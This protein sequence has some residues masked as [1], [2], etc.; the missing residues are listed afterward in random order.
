VSAHSLQMGACVIVYCVD[1]GLLLRRSDAIQQSSPA[2]TIQ[3]DY[4]L[5]SPELP[6]SITGARYSASP[7]AYQDSQR[8]WGDS[9]P[10]NRL[11]Y[12]AP[13][14]EV[15]H[16]PNRDVST[17]TV[18]IA[19]TRHVRAVSLGT[20]SNLSCRTIRSD[21]KS[22]DTSLQQHLSMHLSAPR[23]YLLDA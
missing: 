12:V 1:Q 21:T 14:Y 22:R 11:S 7:R 19:A 13:H 9:F 6:Q 8:A 18:L 3:W 10:L 16:R 5:P 15:R 23:N 20:G 2:A 4:F 17:T